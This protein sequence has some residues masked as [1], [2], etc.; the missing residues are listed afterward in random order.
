VRV[1]ARLLKPFIPLTVTALTAA[2]ALP[3]TLAVNAVSASPALAV[4]AAVPAD[5]QPVAA[6]FISTTRGF[7]LGTVGCRP[8]AFC[9][10]RLIRTTDDGM[11]WRFLTAPDVLVTDP[12][13]VPRHRDISDL[14]F[15]GRRTG[16]LFGPGLW[17]TRDA[18]GRW[19]RLAIGGQVALMAV[20][21]GTVYA[22]VIPPRSAST[23]LYA[24]PAGKNAW[25]RI[26]GVTAGPDASLAVFGRAAWFGSGSTVWATADG[27][28]WHK[29]PFAC[30]GTFYQLT[31]IA[32]ASTSLV[33]FLCTDTADFN[34]AE[35]GMEVMTSSDG[36]TTEHLSG[37]TAPITGDG[38][39]IAMPPGSRAV[40]TFATS[41]GAPSWIG[42][43]A[44]GGKTLRRV[45]FFRA[46]GF[47]R[48]LGYVSRTQAW[49][50]RGTAALLHTSDA[51][52]TWHKVPF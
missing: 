43:S 48:S 35:E 6:S 26:P 28:H 42:R 11:H 38:G 44:D 29:H 36:G 21:S 15:A 32:A 20:S 31:D 12:S 2:A 30:S 1:V 34:T 13:R 16:W 46:G 45:A 5:F 10:A 47:W 14:A 22:V 33:R 3:A 7:V 52:R 41:V 51:G 39:V 17:V 40:I 27:R 18:G 49:I 25:T 50:V 23:R 8:H 9:K 24:S 4:T 37:R 19:R